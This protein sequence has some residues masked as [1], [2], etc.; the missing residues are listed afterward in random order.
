MPF[1][2]PFAVAP[3][4]QLVHI[5]ITVLALAAVSSTMAMLCIGTSAQQPLSSMLFPLHPS[6]NVSPH[7]MHIL[8]RA[9]LGATEEISSA[10]M[11]GAFQPTAAGC[12]HG[13]GL[14]TPLPANPGLVGAT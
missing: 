14:Q 11:V 1:C 5:A 3:V 9:V 2:Q 8:S 7:S 4:L 12:T 13:P 10:R 6:G